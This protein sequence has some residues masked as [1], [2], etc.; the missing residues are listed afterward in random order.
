M[1]KLKITIMGC[2]NSAGVPTIGNFW[3]NCDPH[4]PKNRRTRPSIAVQS[5]TTNLV[6][7][8]GPDFRE[9]INRTNIPMIDA[10]VYTHGH[11]DHVSGIDDLRVLRFRSKKFI[12]IYSNK[13]TI[14]ELS[15]RFDYMFIERAAIYPKS[16]EPH[17]I[18]EYHH[19]VT[20]GDITFTPFEQDHGTCKSIGLR[21]GDFAY[22]TDVVRLDERALEALHG[23]KTWVVDAAGY[24]MET[25]TVHFA[26]RDVLAMNKIVKAE[27]VYLTHM[28]PSMDY[29]TVFKELPDGFE[30][31]Y[32]GLILH[33]NIK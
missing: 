29:K 3:G 18:D 26:L 13:E 27:K 28:P 4:E 7:D 9:Q 22:S 32:D 12:P 25:V 16:V 17:I 30:P 1:T 14:A 33:A 24:N 21:F 5:E 20:V 19:P 11:G 6:V 10:V 31:A 15:Q 8:T 23:V 2:G